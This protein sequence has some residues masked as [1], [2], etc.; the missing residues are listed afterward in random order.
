M[1]AAPAILGVCTLWACWSVLVE[2]Q[3][4]WSYD[5]TYSHGYLVPLAA[6]AILWSRRD[7]MP[8]GTSRPGWWGVAPVVLGVAMQLAGGYYYI[9]WLSGAAIIAYLGGAAVLAG[10]RAALRWAA[11]AL[12]ILVFMIPLPYRADVL[13]R[14]P[15][16]RIS[17]EASGF[18]LQVL[19]LPAIVEGNVIILDDLELGVVDAC[20]G[21]KMFIVFFCLSTTMAVLSRRPLVDRLLIALSAAP[22]AIACN[23]ARLTATGVLYD[24]TKRESIK[25]VFHDMAGWMMMPLALTLLWFEI[26]YLDLLFEKKSPSRRAF[27]MSDVIS[28][29]SAGAAR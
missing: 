28:A 5:P 1:P 21:L 7:R 20:S 16:Q 22:I 13:M 9:R 3:Y 24:M 6:L 2:M 26:K 11:P 14:Q 29:A 4:R 23:V 25:L 12:G 17:T 10:G 19:G 8:A 15:L 18:A 27:Q